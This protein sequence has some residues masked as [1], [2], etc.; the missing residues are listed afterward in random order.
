MAVTGS[1]DVAIELFGGLVTDMAPADLPAGV[2]PDC[3]DVKFVSGSVQT[4]PGLQSIFGAIAGAPK[5]NYLKTYVTPTGLLRLLALDAAGSLWKE[6]SVGVLSLISSTN[7]VGALGKSTS[8]F[9][10]EY[11]ALSDGKT[12]I[13][14]PRQFDDVNYDRVSQVGPGQSPSA[15]DENNA[16]AIIA[17]PSGTSQSIINGTINASPNGLSEVGNVVT[18]SMSFSSNLDILQPGDQVIIAGAGVGGYNGTFTVLTAVTVNN[19]FTYYNPTSGLAA[20]GNGTVATQMTLVNLTAAAFVPAGSSVTLAGVGVAG[21]NGTW[22]T[23]KHAGDPASSTS[24]FAVLNVGGLANSG[25]G[26]VSVNGN[27]SAGIHKLSVVFKTRQGYLTAPPP[28]LSWTAAGSKRVVVSNIPTGPP[29]VVVRILLF[30]LAGQSFFFYSSGITGIAGSNFII[31]D[32]TTTSVT[33]DFTDIGLASQI[34]ADYLFKL[35]ELGECGGVI[36]FSSRLFCWGERN[37]VGNF[38]NLTFDG[39]HYAITGGGNAPL[40]W[41]ADSA[42]FHNAGGFSTNP[43]VWGE[44][45]Q[46]VGDGAT[47]TMGMITQPAY[48][49]ANGVPIIQ[50]NVAYSVRVKLARQGAAPQ[51]N[52]VI[53]LSSASVGTLG[54]FSVAISGVPSGGLFQ[55]FIGSLMASRTSIPSDTLIR[56]YTGGTFSTATVIIDN[57][58][59]FPTNQP[60]NNSL[61]RASRV[62]DPESYDGVTGFR[63]VSENEG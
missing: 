48:Q 28:P 39:G 11:L 35:V 61:I 54:T 23:R 13:D 15:A 59:V 49:D 19:T 60:N 12:G 40:G 9:L 17:S 10:R 2:S 21:Y 58:E 51:G 42:N 53:D 34:S 25:N 4:R 32:N 8:L 44:A 29:N 62:E 52:L 36:D 3:Q 24:F 33:V 14:I 43:A 45:Y 47:A 18:V 50:A 46:I 16:L 7:V 55:E 27:I 38:L 5:V 22:L 26:T 1:T 6:S 41:L 31:S 56:V 30:T 20:S 37:K 57:I 63:N